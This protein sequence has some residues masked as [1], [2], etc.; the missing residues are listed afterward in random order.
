MTKQ[1][2][3]PILLNQAAALPVQDRVSL[4]PMGTL[5]VRGKR[6]PQQVYALKRRP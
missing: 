2:E 4:S 1:V 6:E 5:Q 3:A